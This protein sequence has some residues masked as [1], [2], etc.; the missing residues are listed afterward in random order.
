MTA[1]EQPFLFSPD[2]AGVDEEH[3]AYGL[4]VWQPR[5]RRTYAVVTQE[6]TT[7]LATARIVIDGGRSATP[8][9][10]D[11]ELPGSSRCP[12]ARPGRRARSRASGRSSKASPSTSAR[13]CCTPRRRTSAC[14]ACSC[15]SGR[16]AGAH[17][18]G[19]DFGIHD[20]CD[21]E[22]EE[23]EPVD[24]TA[25]GSA[26]RLD[27]DAEGV[28]IYYGPGAT[29]YVS[30][31]ARATTPSPCTRAGRNRLVGTFRSQGRRRRRRQRLGRPRRDEPAVGDYREGLLVTHDEPETGPSVD[32]ERD[33]TNFSYVAWGQVAR[34][35]HLEVDTGPPTTRASNDRATRGQ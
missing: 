8:M 19:P 2:R 7:T 27:A 26:A 9:S 1:A 16:R 5:R 31:P 11:L 3:T 20:T 35:L 32:D 13:A 30:C 12:T 34:A 33:A 22:T 29:G 14:G 6:G 10:S 25:G 18:Q 23:C 17:R 24:P 4:A 28:D 21:P 15:R